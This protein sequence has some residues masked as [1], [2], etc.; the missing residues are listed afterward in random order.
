MGDYCMPNDTVCPPVCH[1]PAPSYFRMARFPATW[2]LTT[3]AGWETTAFLMIQSVLLHVTPLL[4]LNVE[5][6]R[7]PATW[8][9]TMVV[10]KATSVI[11]WR[12]NVLTCA[13]TPSLLPVPRER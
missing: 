1:T 6:A 12:P 2:D 8:A 4:L 10:G 11:P 9:P 7:K 13:I 3:A 5:W